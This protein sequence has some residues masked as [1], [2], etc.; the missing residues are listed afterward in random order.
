[1]SLNCFCIYL[2]YVHTENQQFSFHSYITAVHCLD[3]MIFILID[4]G[5]LSDIDY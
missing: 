5:P 1:M 2:I 4:V 3:L